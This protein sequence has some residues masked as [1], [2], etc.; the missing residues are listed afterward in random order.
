M[1]NLNGIRLW[2]LFG[3]FCPH[4]LLAQNTVN[5]S[6]TEAYELSEKHYPLLENQS[7]LDGANKLKLENLEKSKLPGIYWKAFGSLQSEAPGLA[8]EGLPFSVDLP[9]YNLR[10]YAEA[11]YLLLDGGRNDARQELEKLQ[12][13][14]EQQALKV[15][16]NT[17]K[18]RVNS[19]FFGTLLLR[20][21]ADLL[22]VTAKDLALRRE[23]LEAAVRHGAAL[24]S[25]VDKIAVRQLEI[26]AQEEQ[27]HSDEMALLSLL[28][29]MVGKELSPEVELS[30]PD[31]SGF[32]WGMALNRPE[33]ELFQLQKEALL[34][35]ESLIEANRK[36]TLSAFATV[37]IGYP[38]PLN[39][40]DD[41][42]APYARGGLNFSWKLFDWGKAGR[43]REL[44]VLRSE[45]IDNQ[46]ETFEHNLN[47]SNEKYR[48]DILKLER[49]ITRDREIAELQS[50][51]LKQLSSQLE[52]G[53]LPVNDYLLQVNA[54]LRAR[55]QLRLHEVQLN[56][57]KVEYMTLRGAL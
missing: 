30:L 27:L 41:G 36:P 23:T 15:D 11:N 25:E 29:N 43:D 7:L 4:L 6:L 48:E 3:L 47:L 39:F 38:N 54:E 37:G 20:G 21:Q 13:K 19:P 52:H 49:Q 17:L 16:L 40:F 32:A 44:L 42:L 5:L 34:A 53:V 28:G 51:I 9:L 18:D 57:I 35:N 22:E 24:E 56:Q 8:A 55:Q 1:V 10:T 46:R 14:T 45:M 12:L 50:K 2:L 26:Q 31:L 33:Q